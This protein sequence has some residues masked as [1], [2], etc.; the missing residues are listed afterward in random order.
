[1][2]DNTK[3]FLRAYNFYNELQ[4]GCTHDQRIDFL[5]DWCKLM[6]ELADDYFDDIRDDLYRNEDSQLWK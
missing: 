5:Y 4:G 6:Y 2:Q 1:M 3:E